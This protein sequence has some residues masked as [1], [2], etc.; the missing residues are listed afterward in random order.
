MSCCLGSLDV[1]LVGI[2]GEQDHGYVLGM[3]ESMSPRV[4]WAWKNQN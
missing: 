2:C 4:A 1:G 3:Y